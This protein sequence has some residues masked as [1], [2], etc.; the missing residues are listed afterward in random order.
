M[1]HA[2]PH[3]A[4]QNHARNE[5][6]RI[7]DEGRKDLT[8]PRGGV[9]ARSRGTG[10]R[11]TVVL[12]EKRHVHPQAF[13]DPTGVEVS[14]GPR[15]PGRAATALLTVR[16]PR[17]VQMH[18]PCE[19]R[20]I[21]PPPVREQPVAPPEGGTGVHVQPFRGAPHGR[22]VVDAPQ[23][24]RPSV[25]PLQVMD[26]RSCKRAEGPAATTATEAAAPGKAAPWTHVARGAAGTLVSEAD[27]D[28][29]AL[30]RRIQ[31]R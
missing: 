30:G 27:G 5:L 10:E 17:D 18:A 20:T 22:P 9:V 23:K 4:G 13:G 28:A 3:G 14:P 21:P 19:T 31:E 25:D 8:H 29:V 6:G 7:G 12:P 26:R 2:A 11:R 24:S 15:R 1:R 16:Q